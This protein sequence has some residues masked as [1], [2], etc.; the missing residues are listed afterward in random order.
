LGEKG[1]E[2]RKLRGTAFVIGILQILIPS[3]Q[4][5]MLMLLMLQLFLDVGLEKNLG[6]GF[7][8]RFTSRIWEIVLGEMKRTVMIFR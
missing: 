2:E 5:H 1:V 7:G 4:K 3:F 8:K 6:V